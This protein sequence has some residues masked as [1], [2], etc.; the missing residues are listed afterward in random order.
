LV[1]LDQILTEEE[2]ERAEE[3]MEFAKLSFSFGAAVDITPEFTDSILNIIASHRNLLSANAEL[4]FQKNRYKKA[5]SK[6]V[7]LNIPMPDEVFN[8]AN[9]ALE[10]TK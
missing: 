5:L 7:C 6:I 8:I 1:D 2:L 3:T 4:S 10:E 9:D